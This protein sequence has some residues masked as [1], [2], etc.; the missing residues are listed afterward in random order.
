[1]KKLIFYFNN[2]VSRIFEKKQA[3]DGTEKTVL[4]SVYNFVG[5]NEKLVRVINVDDEEEIQELVDSEFNYYHVEDFSSLRADEGVYF[6]EINGTYN[7]ERFGFVLLRNN[8][9]SV[10]PLISVTRDRQKAFLT[11]YPTKFGLLPDIHDVLNLLKEKAITAVVSEEQIREQLSKAAEGGRVLSRI[12]V[13]QGIEAINGHAEYY[14]PLIDLN[15]RAGTIKSDGSIDFREIG[16]VINVETGQ[17]LLQ[18]MPEI[19]P[20]DGRDIYGNPIKAVTNPTSG[21]T[22]GENLIPA[23]YDQDIFVS[24]VDGVLKIAK[25]KMFVLRTVVINGDLDY[26]TGN[27][28]FDGSVVIMGSMLPGFRIKAT[29][30]VTIKDSIE[31]AIIDAGGDVKIGGGIVGQDMSKAVDGEKETVKVVCGGN[32]S[33]RYVL[34][35]VVE[36]EGS[37]VV[38]D[39]IINSNVFSNSDITVEAR[40]GKI[41][42]GDATALYTI[43]V[44]VA[45]AASNPPTNLTVGRNLDIERELEAVKKEAAAKS[46]EIA[47]VVSEL[48]IQ[49]GEPVF[50]DSKA[51]I[52]SLT[53][54]KQKKCLELLTKMNQKNGELKELNEKSEEIAQRLILE[55]EPCIIATGT[56]YPGVVL[57][58][59]KNVRKILQPYSNVKFF[60]D[61]EAK[62]IKFVPAV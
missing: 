2:G 16:S 59:K 3:E 57:N 9:L 18:R 13:A 33:C 25:R 29:G 21:Y 55:K 14:K 4:T 53:P 32:L 10:L 24:A 20:V 11:L 5:T 6:D 47:A 31:K 49:F 15:K 27:I 50:K 52:A 40:N 51:F 30:D 46:D 35:A 58:I 60:D 12:L 38:E 26:K 44:K 43:S 8:K 54:I 37:I 36:A 19:K 28:D 56:V 48:R 23:S 7:A 41:I 61:E 1:M 39:F 17:K 34:N 62:E 45:G 42:G 22:C